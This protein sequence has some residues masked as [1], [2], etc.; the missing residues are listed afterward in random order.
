M[1]TIVRDV[2]VTRWNRAQDKMVKT[3]IDVEV[4][5][6]P[7]AIGHAYAGLANH[8]KSGRSNQLGGLVVIKRLCAR[9]ADEEVA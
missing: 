8:N 5:L 7:E 4:E 9:P 6:D 1:K 3:L 2:P